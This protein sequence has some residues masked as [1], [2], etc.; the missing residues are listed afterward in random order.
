MNVYILFSGGIDSSALI[1]YYREL[2]YNIHLIFVEYGQKAC[3]FEYNSV[4]K[5][6]TYYDLSVTKIQ[7]D[8]QNKLS[9]TILARNSFLIF[10][11]ILA[12]QI[13]KGIISLGVHSGT[14]YKDCSLEFIETTRDSLNVQ[15]LDQVKIDAP[16]IEMNK[17]EIWEY[18]KS[19]KVPLKLTYSCELGNKQPCDTC[20][21]CKD[22]KKLYDT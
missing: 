3:N 5:I 14:P 18:A 4:K 19:K 2:G 13:N 22:L 16:F 11:T 7:L 8:L 15:G 12:K 9:G 6:S 1:P 10:G 20:P 21:S 17:H